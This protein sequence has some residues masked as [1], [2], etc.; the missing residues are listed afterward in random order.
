[1]VT[2]SEASIEVTAVGANEFRELWARV[3]AAGTPEVASLELQSEF[4]KGKVA[5]Y[6]LWIFIGMRFARI[7]GP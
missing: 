5:R 3:G 6:G 4:P 7:L 1:M 2:P